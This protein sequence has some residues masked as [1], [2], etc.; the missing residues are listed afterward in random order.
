VEAGRFETCGSL[1]D[2]LAYADGEERY[3]AAHAKYHPIYRQKLY[4]R[5]YYDIFFFDLNG[6]LI[7]SVFKEPVYLLEKGE[8]CSPKKRVQPCSSILRQ[9]ESDE[10][11]CIRMRTMRRE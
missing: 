5:S 2:E 1:Q 7:Y 6:D 4:D 8:E 10:S 9:T 3:H 11:D